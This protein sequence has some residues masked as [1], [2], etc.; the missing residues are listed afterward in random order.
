[1][2]GGSELGK[3]SDVRVWK[4][5]LCLPWRKAEMKTR[6]I[7]DKNNSAAESDYSRESEGR[8]SILET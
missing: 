8:D 7:G 6:Q 1:M 4:A 5:E 2:E 3:R